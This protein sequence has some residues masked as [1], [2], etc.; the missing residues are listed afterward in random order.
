MHCG[1]RDGEP[2]EIT[3]VYGL[4]VIRSSQ[5][6]CCPTIAAAD[7]ACAAGCIGLPAFVSFCGMMGLGDE[8]PRS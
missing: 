6:G 5:Q 2:Q 4:W 8:P 7:A 1:S 3:L